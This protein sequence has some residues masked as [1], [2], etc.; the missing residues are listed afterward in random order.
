MR[1]TQECNQ[2]NVKF[3]EK[4]HIY[5]VSKYLTTKYFVLNYKEANLQ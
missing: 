3:V 5:I 2:I 4:E 1:N